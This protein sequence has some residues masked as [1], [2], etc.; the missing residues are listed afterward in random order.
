MNIPLIMETR[1]D[2][3][4]DSQEVV[5][6]YNG[7]KSVM[8]AP[9]RPYFYS[10]RSLEF[11]MAQDISETKGRVKLLSDL[12]EHTVFRYEVPNVNY[13]NEINKSLNRPGLDSHQR[14]VQA[15]FENHTKFIDRILI[16]Q[17]D[18]ISQYANTDELKFFYFDIETLMDN[19]I[20]KKIVTSIAYATNDRKVHSKQGDEKEILSWF[21]DSIQNINPDIIV[22]YYMRDF[23]LVRI[24]E[25]CKVHKLDYKKL[26]RDGKVHYY[27][28]E[29]DRSVTMK[30]GGRVLW[31]LMDSVNA[32]QTIYGIK[33]KK[34]KTVCEWFGVEGSDWVKV[35][36]TNSA[37]DVDED[38]LC[39]HNEDD[40]RRTFGLADIYWGNIST[41]AEMF[42]VP[43]D[44]VINNTQ[45]T[46][47]GIF[48]GRGLLNL[49]IRSD[50]MNQDRHPEIFRR[51]K[52][53]GESNYEA[54]MVG[55]YQPGLHKKVY[56]I[57]F[58]GFY[59]SLM[60]AFNLSPDTTKILGYKPYQD[61][62][63]S[64]V[65]GNKI[66]YY[67]PDKVVK[68]TIIIG[69]KQDVDGFLRKELRKIREERNKIKK[70]YK[71][72]SKKEKE[73][74]NSRQ[75]SLKV[76]QNIPS[77]LN[78]SS[79]SRYGDIGCT[80]MTVGI[81]REILGDLKDYIDKDHP[82]C[83]ESDTDGIYTNENP[84]MDDINSFLEDLIATKFNLKESA[85]ISLDLDKYNTGYFIKQKNYILQSTRGD[86]IYHGAG[87]KSSRLPRIFD[88]AR[89]ILCEALLSEETDDIKLT[90]NRLC[91]I[92]QYDLRDFTIRTTLHKKLNQYK[93]GALQSK[94][95]SQA[96]AIGIHV[97][98]E[99][100]LEYVKCKG[101][102]RIIQAVNT[103]KEIDKEYYINIIGKL[104]ENL[105]FEQE[106]H[107]RNI[108]TLDAWW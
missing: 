44:F 50:G 69:V 8:L 90:L 73:I 70:E 104:A 93:P 32:D 80:I 52:A 71:T 107:T 62:F 67:I 20:D 14:V 24:I 54:A 42:K 76:V 60:A 6:W 40:I 61:E 17:P 88:S 78:G 56:K 99:T 51:A 15:V 47:A 86:L 105:G 10:K 46:L 72:A 18:F 12:K 2:E 87:L 95:G 22:G 57:D 92:D 4:T 89:D 75:W 26:A 79:I 23:D 108:K 97:E 66:V 84:N 102:Y 19:Y 41:L 29:R 63:T 55:I 101:E 82:V 81:G 36:M 64:E 16:D 53:K 58:A 98:Q 43:L 83:I 91:N 9:F 38:T 59:P 31:D 94:L 103:V 49:N 1:I 37:H 65:V 45:A 33:N 34:M 85:E 35:D 48:M 68:K 77:G 25:R 106:F 27:K 3:D 30:I 13:I 21:L 100:Q 28:S 11:D 96:K 5:M 7:H 39:Q 74:L